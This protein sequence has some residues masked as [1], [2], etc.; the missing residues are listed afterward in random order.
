MPG[1]PPRG[2]TEEDAER[3]AGDDVGRI[4]DEE[5]HPGEPDERGEHKERRADAAPHTAGKRG[6]HCKCAEGMPR[7][8]GVIRW[9]A[10]RE[11]GNEWICDAGARA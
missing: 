11:H 3:G 6:C 8:E 2:D 4:M 10:V 1:N 5:I 7:R 9:A